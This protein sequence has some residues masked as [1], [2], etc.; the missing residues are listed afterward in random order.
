MPLP[1]LS[2]LIVV[3]LWFVS[4]ILQL[5]NGLW[6]MV[7]QTMWSVL[8]HFSLNYHHQNIHIVLLL[9]KLMLDKCHLFSVSLNSVLLIPN[10]PF[11]FISISKLTRSLN[12]AI[13]FTFNSFFMQNKSTR[14]IIRV[15][16]E[17]SGLYYLQPLISSICV[18]TESPNLLHRCLG[19]SRLSNWRKWCSAFLI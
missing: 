15:I 7:L 19:H 8:P 2:L 18:T 17:S 14:Q 4:L 10:Y 12:C 6:I 13:T 3:I 5:L 9:R 11:N 1:H 16:T